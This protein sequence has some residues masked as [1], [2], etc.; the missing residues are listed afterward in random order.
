MSGGPS[1]VNDEDAPYL[2]TN[3]FD[4]EVPIL[5]ICYGLQILAHNIIPGSVEKAERREFGRSDLIVD[6]DSD[7]LS[8]IRIRCLY[9]SW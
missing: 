8:N 9:E 7:L 3:V 6:D 2:N 5:G 4:F 1:S